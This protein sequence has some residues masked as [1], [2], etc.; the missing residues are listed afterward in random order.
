MHQAGTVLLVVFIGHP[1]VL[2]HLA[3][4]R[5][6]L[7]ASPHGTDL[8]LALQHANVALRGHRGIVLQLLRQ[9]FTEAWEHRATS[10]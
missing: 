8:V 7:T 9:T 6:D 2:L 10:G 3:Q 1:Q 5:E 4:A